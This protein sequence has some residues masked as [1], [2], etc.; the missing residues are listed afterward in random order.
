MGGCFAYSCVCAS[1]C[2]VPMEARRGRQ[3]PWNGCEMPLRGLVIKPESSGKEAS[4]LIHLSS[5]PHP[6]VIS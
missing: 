5:G 2:L 4:A 6:Q 3:I 1:M